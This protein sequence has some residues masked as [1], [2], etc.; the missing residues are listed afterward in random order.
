[1]SGS[2]G[3]WWI[4]GLLFLATTINYI[5]RQTLSVL[6]PTL[7]QELHL[8]EQD[9]AN[10]V[11]AF[12]VPYTIMYAGGGRLMDYLGTRVGL[13]LA[14]AWWSGATML[15]G[16]ARGAF[17]LGVFRAFLGVAEPCVF[18]AGIKSCA[19]LFLPRERALPVGIFSSGS[20]VG[21]VIAPPLV[22]WFT[23]RFGW[24]YAFLI[25]GLSGFCW[26]PFWL[27]IRPKPPAQIEQK[28]AAA[29]IPWRALRGQ[30]AVWGLVSAR[31]LGDPVWYFYLF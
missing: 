12:L 9:Y 21:A 28:A 27:W 17:S 5:D 26:L 1:M 25:A 15:T 3:R 16:F 8:S 29:T 4:V 7:R 13:A 6:V 2:R 30:R 20:S 22:A 31:F 23:L 14:F 18:P 24:R 10:V 19:E 11:T